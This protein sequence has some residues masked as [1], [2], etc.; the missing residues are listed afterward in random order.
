MTLANLPHA[1]QVAAIL[2]ASDEALKAA[3]Q[4]HQSRKAN[5]ARWGRE[6]RERCAC[7]KMTADRAKKRG[8]R[9]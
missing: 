3:W 8:H 1:E 5:E 4:R 6:I 2:T 7:G 9:C